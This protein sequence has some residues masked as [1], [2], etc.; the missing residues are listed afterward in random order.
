MFTEFTIV[1]VACALPPSSQE[2][3]LLSLPTA[4]NCNKL[5][6]L[7]VSLEV[8]GRQCPWGRG[9]ELENKYP[10]FLAHWV[11]HL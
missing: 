5:L 10:H 8:Q 2:A 11:G 9:R 4:L 6:L 3:P 7:R 1:D